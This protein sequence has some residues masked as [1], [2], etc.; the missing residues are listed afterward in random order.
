MFSQTVEIA[1]GAIHLTRYLTFDDQRAI[2]RTCLD[3]GGPDAGFYTPVVR[4][5]HPMSVRMLCLGRH[6]NARTYTY[7]DG[8]W[9][10]RMP[11]QLKKELAD[12][13]DAWLKALQDA[14]TCD[15]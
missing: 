15:S 14:G 5:E 8:Q 13:P 6:W 2:V 12:G 7:E 3:L 11:A 4:G 10:E 1:P 9:K